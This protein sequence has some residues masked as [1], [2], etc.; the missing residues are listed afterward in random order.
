MPS[1][2]HFKHRGFRAIKFILSFGEW[3]WTW[4]EHYTH[5]WCSF[6]FDGAVFS[7]IINRN[8]DCS[9]AWWKSLFESIHTQCKKKELMPL[10]IWG[11]NIWT[12]TTYKS[13]MRLWIFCYGD[14]LGKKICI[15][16]HWPSLMLCFVKR[17]NHVGHSRL[18]FFHSSE[19]TSLFRWNVFKGSWVC[20][21][22]TLRF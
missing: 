9:W 1:E 17:E 4:I 16:T 2:H 18:F 10:E 5:K 3:C 11:M 8:F 20:T 19:K 14:R 6:I 22:S 12:C 21:E 13:D 15:L 7:S